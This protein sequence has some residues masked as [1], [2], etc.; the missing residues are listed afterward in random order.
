MI[1]LSERSLAVLIHCLKEHNPSSIS[2]VEDPDVTMYTPEF[3]NHLRQ[4]VGDELVAKGF[5]ENYEP[6]D[7]GADLE[8]LIDEIGRLFMYK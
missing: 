5:D 1:K 3:Y 6:N 7:Y 4:I 8:H 2:T